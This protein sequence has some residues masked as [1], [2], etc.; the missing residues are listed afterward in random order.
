[1]MKKLK[2][3]DKRDR[4]MHEPVVYEKQEKLS[5]SV[6][7]HQ[8]GVFWS[9]IYRKHCNNINEEW[10]DME[11]LRYSEHQAESEKCI[12]YLN[13]ERGKVIVPRALREHYDMVG[14]MMEYGGEGYMYARTLTFLAQLWEHFN[15]MDG[16]LVH[17]PVKRMRWRPLTERKVA[18]SLR[19][20][21]RG[22]QPGPDKIRGEILRWLGESEICLATLTTALNT[23]MERG[24][25]PESWRES[26]TVMI[27][28]ESKAE[29][30]NHRP[31]ALTNTSYKLMMTLIKKQIYQHLLELGEIN[32]LQAG[33]TEG[34]RMEDNV[35]LM[36]YC[37]RESKKRRKEL[38][39]MAIDF[40]KA[41][42]SVERGCLIRVMKRCGCDPMVIETVAQ[43]Y[44]NDSIEVY[45]GNKK[46]F[47]INI[48]SG[49]RQGCTL[50][51]ILFVMVV[52]GI[53]RK[54]QDT[55]LGY[56]NKSFYLPVLFYADDSLVLSNDRQEMEDM[57]SQLRELVKESGLEIS[58]LKSK[59]LILNRDN[60]NLQNQ[61][62]LAE[63][64]V[65]DTIKYLG[66]N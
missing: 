63:I 24:M 48:S 36:E 61:S 30:E 49:I 1:M 41:F 38:I 44:M 53:I 5:E 23:V 28:K 7:A 20:I 13:K 3:N 10:N 18:E 37:L 8:M 2:G 40:E 9:S 65:V 59:C 29:V 64:E 15:C 14:E 56:R 27:P 50:S 26:R 4:R 58:K 33:F 52:N 25:C 34:R 11:K 43:L 45:L 35:F 66:I 47:K 12:M 19:R 21:K 32:D 46:I 62:K 55:G 54:L 16:G 31:V 51:P 60:R 57:M 22:K 42:D 17:M 6:S 39:V